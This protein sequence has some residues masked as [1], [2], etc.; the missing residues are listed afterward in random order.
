MESPDGPDGAQVPEMMKYWRKIPMT[1]KSGKINVESK[2]QNSFEGSALYKKIGQI[3][4]IFLNAQFG[5]K[6]KN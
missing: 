3:M 2:V 6:E 5:L 4:N 1:R